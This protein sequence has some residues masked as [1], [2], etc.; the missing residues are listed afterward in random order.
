MT[1]HLFAAI[2]WIWALLL[3]AAT[4]A[5]SLERDR[6]LTIG[7]LVLT[8]TCAAVAFALQVMG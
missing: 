1:A 6:G 2:V 4:G 5:S 7:G 3:A 8:L